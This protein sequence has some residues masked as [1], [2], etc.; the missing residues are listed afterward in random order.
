MPF[1][2]FHHFI[3]RT[4]R[5]LLS[6]VVFTRL[7]I[8][9]AVIIVGVAGWFLF[10]SQAKK[11]ISDI[12]VMAGKPLPEIGGRTNFVLLGAGGENHDGPDLTDTMIFISV[13]DDTGETTLIS[14]P[15]DLWL[16]SREQKINTAYHLGYDVQATMGG[17]LS[18]KSAVSEVIGQPVQFAVYLDFSTF[19]KAIDLLGG[20]DITVDKTF[21]DYKYPIAGRENDPCGGDPEFKCRYEHLHFD[22]GPQHMDGT[23]ALKFVRSRYSTDLD[24]GTD[25]ARSKRQEKVITAVKNKLLSINNLKNTKVYKQLYD[26]VTG[27]L[28]TDITPDYY[29][30]LFRL[31]LKA[32][33]YPLKTYSLT[34]PD[35]LE[36]PPISDKYQNQWVLIPKN[37]DYKALSSYVSSLLP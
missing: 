20:I 15:R 24:E 17:L 34:A 14:I 1:S 12:E 35:Q 6:H 7:L 16:P 2:K 10:K 27:S 32:R 21:D 19:S 3:H 36:N 13:K 37:G 8:I 26:L 33:Q 23:T 29:S 4:R 28:A 9:F 5:Q 11:I 31:A 18:A 30:T 22:A 25:F